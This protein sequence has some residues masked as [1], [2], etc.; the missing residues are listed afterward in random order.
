MLML[1]A[2]VALIGAVLLLVCTYKGRTLLLLVLVLIAGAVLLQALVPD[3]T[4]FAV[5]PR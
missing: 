1:V 3:V 4:P 5:A 2:L